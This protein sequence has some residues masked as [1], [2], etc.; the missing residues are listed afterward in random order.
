MTAEKKSPARKPRQATAPVMEKI[1]DVEPIG[2][3]GS[4]QVEAHE[5]ST[6]TQRA[7]DSQAEALRDII[8]RD[9]ADGRMGEPGSY[10]DTVLASFSPDDLE[11]LHRMFLRHSVPAAEDGVLRPDDELVEGWREGVYP[12]KNRMSRKN[13]EKQKYHLQVEL[14]KLQKWVKETGQRIIILFEGRDAAGKGGTIKRFM[15]HLNP[16]GARVV[17]LEKPTESEA[18]QWYFQR[19]IK[20]LPTRGEIVLFDRSWYNRAGVERVMGFCTPA[21]YD[22]FMREVPDFERNLV[23]SGIILIKFWFSVSQDEQR[24]RFKEREAHP[25]KQWKLSPMDKASVDKWDDYTAAKEAMFFHTDTAESP[26]I[27]V[28]SNCKKRARLNAMRYVLSRIPY[29]EK[30][31]AQIGAIDPLLV[32]RAGALYETDN[33]KLRT[34][35]DHG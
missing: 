12:Y 28:K 8:S 27:V 17:A 18:G 5:I 15:E 4:P 22:E 35:I 10:L 7:E 14:L 30:D 24:R 33:A 20:H 2:K 25:L 19:Y 6:K 11:K 3:P 13:Y 1:I 9:I 23:R 21:E 26:W 31:N 32:V 34:A 29:Q 16:R